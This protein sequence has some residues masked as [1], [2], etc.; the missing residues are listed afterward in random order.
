MI[1]KLLIISLV[2]LAILGCRQEPARAEISI[3]DI[4]DKIPVQKQSLAY[5]IMDSEFNYND[6]FISKD[7]KI[8]EFTLSSGLG[9]IPKETELT[10][11]L[12]TTLVKFDDVEVLKNIPIVKWFE[13]SP[14]FY[15][16]FKRIGGIN[17]NQKGNSEWDMGFGITLISLK[18]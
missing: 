8:K 16:G 7:F 5:S 15:G 17:A 6:I 4:V 11:N 14:Y 13:I 1:K 18:Y 3:K 10:F 2:S 12:G 9:I